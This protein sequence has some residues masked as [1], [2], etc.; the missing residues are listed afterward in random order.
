[1]L[2]L[3]NLVISIAV[4]SFI[5][6]YGYQKIKDAENKWY[7]V[8][9]LAGV[10]LFEIFLIQDIHGIHPVIGLL[11]ILLVLFG[12]GLAFRE[13]EI[14]SGE[15]HLTGLTT[16]RYFFEEVL[17]KEMKRAQRSKKP[18]AVIMLDLD[19][20]K[21]VNDVHGHKVGDKV[22]REVGKVIRETIRE[23]DTAVRIGGDEI[24]ILLPETDEKGAEK[25]LERLKENLQK[26]SIKDIKVTASAG[27]TVW[28]S[29][30]NFEEIFERVDKELYKEKER[31][32]SLD[33]R[34]LL[35]EK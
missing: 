32:K 26:I 30:E 18:M 21:L 11:S 29:G 5:A 16:R 19:D 31:K 34:S 17:R 12:V 14:R 22:L 8:M 1:M 3:I 15:D 25:V 23:I 27:V 4:L 13:K 9:F 33:Q 28:R 10:A 2:G 35:P 6:I 20:F 24:L 7:S